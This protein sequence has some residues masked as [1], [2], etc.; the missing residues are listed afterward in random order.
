ML[1]PISSKKGAV[2]LS[3]G[4]IVIIVLAMSM[5]ILGI[6]LVRNIFFGAT[7]NVSELNNKVRDEIRSLFQEENQKIVIRLTEDTA[8]VNQ[9]EKFGV[10][11]GVKNIKTG[12]TD[13]TEFSYKVE[14]DDPEIERSCDVTEQEALSWIRF[15]SGSFIISPGETGFA[16]IELNIPEDAPLCSTRYRIRVWETDE[17]PQNVYSNPFFIVRIESG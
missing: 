3:I 15:G 6:V 12:E 9:G 7:D 17:G 16:R 8:K 1:R 11:F 10:A 4:T 2:E 13:S 5:L 14:L